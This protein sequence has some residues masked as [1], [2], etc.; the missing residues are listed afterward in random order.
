MTAPTIPTLDWS[1]FATGADRAGFAAD[2]G[3]ACRETGF[4]LLTNHGIPQPLIDGVFAQGDAFFARPAAEKR[5]LDIRQ[6]PHNRGWAAEGSEAL[7]EASGQVDRKQAFNVGFDLSPDDPRVLAGEPFRGVNVWPDVPGF[8]D[9]ML[10]YY[11]AALALAVAVHAAI[12]IDLGLPEGFFPPHFTEPMATLRILAYPAATEGIGAG[13]HTD[14]G[15]IT[16]LMTDGVAGLQVKPRGGDWTDVPHVPGAFVVNIG[17]LLMRWSNDI[18]VS[19]PHRVLP[20]PRPRRS[21]AFFLDPNPDS[22][23]AALPGTGTPKRPP[24]TGADYLRMRLDATYRPEEG[25]A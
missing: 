1:R 10:A 11:D 25:A 15:S 22:L 7:D 9:T 13:A 17:D 18:Y 4:F 3:R 12:E 5:A 14:Y 16:L 6:S 24:I 23:V 2:L 20:P 8:R 21:I 19:T